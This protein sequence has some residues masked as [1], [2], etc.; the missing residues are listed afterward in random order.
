MT[1]RKT[2]GRWRT[3]IGTAM[4]V[5]TIIAGCGGDDAAQEPA[6]STVE[7]SA[8]TPSG[9]DGG[10][11]LTTEEVSAAVGI[12]MTDMGSCMWTSDGAD[13]FYSTSLASLFSTYRQQ[14]EERFDVVDVEGIGDEAYT[15]AN[16]ALV[17]LAGEI[18]FEIMVAPNI[19]DADLDPDL[20]FK[21]AER[22]LAELVLGR[23]T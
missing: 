6:A 15:S 7:R 12:D 17:V 20:D 21:A 23:L 1:H 10:C 18:V 2:I 9:E 11:P 13:V 8:A 19:P 5:G 16:T 4:V 3:T 14:N 22:E